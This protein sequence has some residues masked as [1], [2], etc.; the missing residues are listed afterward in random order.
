MLR[1]YLNGS[2]VDL[3]QDESVNLTVQFTDL[4]SIN[5]TTGS[6]SQTFRIPAT[7]NNL[8]ILGQVPSPTAVGVNLKTKIPAELVN[9]TIP[10][11]RGFCQIKQMYVQKE[12]Y[13]DIELV[14]FGGAVDLKT[15]IGDGM[16]SEL[17]L[18]ADN[19]DLLYAKVVGSWIGSAGSPGPEI[20]Y[21]L[22]DKGGNWTFN[23]PYNYPWTASDGLYLGEL[24]PMFQAKYVFDQ[25]MSAA[26]FTYSSAFLEATGSETFEKIYLPGLNGSPTPLSSE[27]EEANA[28]AGLTA[29]FTG[30]TYTTLDLEDEATGGNDEGSNWN[31]TTNKYTAPYTGWYSINLTYSYD[32]TGHTEHVFIDVVK[33]GSTVLLSAA[34]IIPVASNLSTGFQDFVLVAGDTIEVKGNVTGGHGHSIIGNDSTVDGIRTSLEIIGGFPFSGFEVDVARNMPEMKQIDFVIGLQKMFNLVFIPDKNIPN[35]LLIEPFMDYIATGTAKDWSDKIDYS[36]DVVISPTTD[37]Q[38]KRYEWTHSPG[39]DFISEAVNS[40]LDR[41]YGRFRINDPANDFATGEKKVQTPFAPFMTSLIP[42]SSFPIHRSL[43]QDGTG[44]DNPPPMLAYYHGLVN[45]YGTWY[46]R[47]DTGVEQTL[48]T[49]PSFSNYSVNVPALT[50]YDL[51]FGMEAGFIPMTANPVNTLYFEYWAQYSTE[52]YSPEA[53]LMRCTMRLSKN[54]LADFEFS[55]RIYIRDSYWRVLKLSYDANVEGVCT[56]E[57]IKELTDVAICED[58]PTSIDERTNIVL[59]NGS[60]SASPDLGSQT[61]CELYGYRWVAN[62]ATVGSVTP[63]YVC[64]PLNQTNQPS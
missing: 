39:K 35:H 13:A 19:H 4:Q 62:T 7:Q 50:S 48:T 20:V 38:A 41:V 56:V 8:D 12:T 32:Q 26:G 57:L 43:K 9:N 28:R 54:D 3:Y 34:N 18:S 40:N 61:C 44:I 5:A 25:I 11:L 47:N 22:I 14:F 24:T 30:S 23:A 21:G 27:S 63:L 58:T 46:L 33:N 64:R 60:S 2:E 52:L 59:F 15:A 31:N 10:I 55:D 51:N 42:G 45:E 6:Y 17:D 1:L 53:R 36:M 37:L 49:F 29:D 16:L